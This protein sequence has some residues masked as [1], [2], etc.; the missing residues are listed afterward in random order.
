MADASV[1][2]ATTD[3]SVPLGRAPGRCGEVTEFDYVAVTTL[4]DLAIRDQRHDPDY[5]RLGQFWVSSRK[6]EIP[7]RSG[8]PRR[9][10]ARMLCVAWVDGGIDG[11]QA[12]SLP[13]D[14]G[15][16]ER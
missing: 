2:L 8:L 9:P 5:D 7:M 14:W 6:L 12:M 1:P 10:P 16:P 11:L 4:R 3:V 13:D 15:P